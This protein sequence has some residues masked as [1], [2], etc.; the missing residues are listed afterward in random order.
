MALATTSQFVTGQNVLR[1]AA[2]CAGAYIL[3]GMVSTTSWTLFGVSIRRFLNDDLR[4][5]IFN[6]S[7]GLMIAAFAVLLMLARG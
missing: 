4:L 3:T 7:M 2:I 1:E 5:R 6:I